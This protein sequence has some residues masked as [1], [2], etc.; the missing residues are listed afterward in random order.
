M[1][2]SQKCK[3]ALILGRVGLP[4]HCVAQALQD[5]YG[6]WASPRIVPDYAAYAEAAFREFG[7]RVK[8]W[9][10]IQVSV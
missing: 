5:A 6:G 8:R 10:V 4:I 3:Q 2:C 1:T 9:C 7:G